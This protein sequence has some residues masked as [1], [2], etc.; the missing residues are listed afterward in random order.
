MDGVFPGRPQSFRQQ[1]RPVDDCSPG[2]GG[3]TLDGGTRGGI[4][5]GEMDRCSKSQSWTTACSRM[6]ERDGKNQG[7]DT[8]KQA[9]SCWLARHCC[10]ATSGTNLYPCR[11]HDGVFLWCL[12]CFVLLRFCLH[13]FIEVLAF[14]SIVLRY[15]ACASTATRVPSFF[16]FVS[17]EVSLFPSTFV[18][19]PFPLCTESTSFVFS[20]RMVFSTL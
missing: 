18:Q 9:G 14:R 12:L 4:F 20:F 2:R 17:L 15:D 6:P 19:L 3:M 10:L 7:G 5:H 13:A 1:R 16:P 8:P 11:Y